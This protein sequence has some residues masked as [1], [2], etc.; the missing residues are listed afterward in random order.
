M[1]I[2]AIYYV[3]RNTE[4]LLNFLSSIQDLIA[5]P[6]VMYWRTVDYNFIISFGNLML[7]QAFPFLVF[8]LKSVFNSPLDYKNYSKSRITLKIY[9]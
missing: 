1:E 8:L 5:T 6:I 4:K 7:T 9:V 3:L 2:S